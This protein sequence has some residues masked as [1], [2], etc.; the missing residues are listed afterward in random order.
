MKRLGKLC[1]SVLLSFGLAASASAASTVNLGV[2]PSM[3]TLELIHQYQPL[4]SYLQDQLEASVLVRTRATYDRFARAVAEGEFDL[5][6]TAPHLA[7]LAEQQSG[8]QP[9]TSFAAELRLLAVLPEGA[10]LQTLRQQSVLTVAV[11]DRIAWVS[12]MGEAW[13]AQE[14]PE[15]EIQLRAFR[16][17]RNTMRAVLQQESDLT[18]VGS[19]ALARLDEELLEGL[20]VIDTGISGPH[21]VVLCRA[22]QEP[23]FCDKAAAVLASFPDSPRGRSFF[24]ASQLQGWAA[25]STLSQFDP[26]LQQ[27]QTRL[28]EL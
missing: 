21:L 1:C 15:A 22:E 23:D 2:L 12:V 5:V 19:M 27:I 24:Q 14:M 20:S 6:I 25:A 7:R 3:E 9:L 18:F 8:L 10:D 16:S 28:P 17:H 4:A 11:P 13:L 26:L